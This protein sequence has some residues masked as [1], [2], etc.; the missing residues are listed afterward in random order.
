[1]LRVNQAVQMK[2]LTLSSINVSKEY[3]QNNDQDFSDTPRALL[4]MALS[5]SVKVTIQ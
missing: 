3:Y 2:G 4:G 5:I 1:M